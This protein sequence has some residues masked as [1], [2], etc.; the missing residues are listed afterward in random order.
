VTV[1]PSFDF[2]DLRCFVSPLDETSYYFLP[3]AADLARDS[4]GRPQL[5]FTE[6]AHAAYLLLTARW[7]ASARDLEDLR[8]E[9]ARRPRRPDAGPLTLAFAPARSPSC[10][11]LIGD[12]GGEFETLA[13][14][15]TSGIPPYDAV[16]S[17]V[18]RDERRARASAAVR[19]ERG[20]L[21]IEYVAE[22][23]SSVNESATFHS[24]AEDLRQ[25]VPGW[26]VQHGTSDIHV[27]TSLEHTISEPVRAFADVGAIV[28]TASVR[29]VT[30]GQDAA[31]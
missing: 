4:E 17:L 6:T 31:D 9:L 28:A 16:F 15:P 12:G 23:Q 10:R 19:G 20:F 13:T 2:R 22:V 1:S 3:L 7:G 18:L 30:G 27:S 21:G 14:S 24:R 26:I 8:G 29:S 11:L 5:S 25:E